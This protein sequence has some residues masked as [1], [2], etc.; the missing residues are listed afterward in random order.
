[1]KHT[2]LFHKS[3]KKLKVRTWPFKFSIIRARMKGELLGQGEGGNQCTLGGSVLMSFFFLMLISVV[4]PLQTRNQCQWEGYT[5]KRGDQVFKFI[6]EIFYIQQK[7][8]CA[9]F[10]LKDLVHNYPGLKSDFPG[11]LPCEFWWD[12]TPPTG[13]LRALILSIPTKV[14]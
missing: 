3:F 6:V 2:V 14:T 12:R 7:R 9:L 11:L 4:A 10:Y 13:I 5:G 8:V 1:M